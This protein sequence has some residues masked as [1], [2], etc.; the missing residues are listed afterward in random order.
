MVNSSFNCMILLLRDFIYIADINFMATV[1]LPI[2]VLP[3][4][5]ERTTLRMPRTL[6]GP[7][8]FL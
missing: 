2:S 5:L 4:E 6:K 8:N 1:M 7:I 3:K